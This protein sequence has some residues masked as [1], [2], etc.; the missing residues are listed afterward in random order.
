MQELLKLCKTC[1][2]NKQLE[3]FYIRK[4]NGKHRN[5]CKKCICEKS[6]FYRKNNKEK[7][8]KAK[9]Q[10]AKKN[11]KH[12]S[13]YQKKYRKKH[14]KRIYKQ[15]RNIEKEKYKTNICFKVRKNT[16]R[17]ILLA[18][19][20]KCKSANTVELLGCSI[21]EYKKYLESKFQEGM[22]WENHGIYGWHIDHIKPCASFDLTNPEEQKKCFHYTNTQPL[23]ADEN[24][25]KRDHYSS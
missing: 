7:V 5:I 9:K 16:Q 18:L 25:K 6:K 12:I 10:Y 14:K 17:R 8:A 24:V 4:D 3:N 2:K 1:N 19:K 15:I 23:W 22:K 20:G 21:E 11:E 13:E